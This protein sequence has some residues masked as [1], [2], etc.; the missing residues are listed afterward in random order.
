M[1]WTVDQKKWIPF[2]MRGETMPPLKPKYEY[3][4]GLPCSSDDDNDV[5]VDDEKIHLQH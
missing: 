1:V 4:D 3:L 5:D 2:G